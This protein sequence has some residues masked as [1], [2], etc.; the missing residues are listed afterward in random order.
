M[1]VPAV[2]PSGVHFLRDRT[3]I[4]GLLRSARPDAGDLVL[5]LGAG[6]GV[7]TA[8]LAGT[9]AR[10]VAVERDAAFA[11]R[12][13]RRFAHRPVTVVQ[14]DLRRVRLP[15]RPFAVVA[16]LP[17]ATGTA[18]LRRLLGDPGLRLRG[19]DLLVEWGFARRLTRPVPRDAETAGWAARYQLR[20]A[21]RVPPA[22]FSPAP[23]VAAAHLVVRPRELDRRTLP[24]LRALLADAYRR[25]AAP[26]TAVLA[27]HVPGGRA[28][29]LA[30]STGIAPPVLAGAVPA[31]AWA[32]L[33]AAVVV[34]EPAARARSIS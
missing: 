2:N 19:A 34:A 30:R 22:A 21:R 25:P 27:A 9:G 1:R 32:E 24:V 15:R 31:A 14:D 23:R 4:A 20:I 11:A 17:F 29:R 10:V 13:R 8:A 12:L 33:A 28:H 6:P 18:T 3:V 5:E 26:L 16:N 7:L